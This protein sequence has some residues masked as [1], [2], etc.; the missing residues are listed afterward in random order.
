MSWIVSLALAATTGLALASAAPA[1]LATLA[2]RGLAL[3]A[4]APAL[5]VPNRAYRDPVHKFSFKMYADW[6]Q[7]PVEITEK[8]EVAK[9]YEK[10]ERGDWFSPEINVFRIDKKT[11]AGGPVTGLDPKKIDD[12]AVRK[13]LEAANAPKTVFD[14]AFGNLIM[15]QGAKPC[16]PAS[17]KPI[18]SY[19]K[20]DGKLW[21][22]EIHRG[23]NPKDKTEYLLVMLV[24]FEKEGIE[25]GIRFSGPARR[26]KEFEP[27]LKTMAKSFVFF[28]DKAK[29]VVSLDKVLDGVNITP[30]RRGEIQKG[31]V[32]GWG[33]EV[34]PKKN[35]V[36]IYNTKNNKNKL[37]AETIAKRIEGIREQ[38][39]EVQFP[40]A[41]PVKAVSIVRVCGDRNEYHKYGGP[42]GSAGYWNSWAE[43]L[44]FY[45]ASPAKQIDD[46]TL[47]VLYH[48]A[49]HQYIYYSVGSVAP[50]SWF[51]EGHGDY[52]AGAKWKSNKWKVGPFD[53]RV[54]TVKNAIRQGPRDSAVQKDE[55]TGKE[56]RIYASDKG[57]TPLKDLVAFS[58]GDYYSYPGVSYA[59][60]WSLIYFLREEVPNNKKYAEKWGKILDTY[61]TALKREV[62]KEGKLRRRG[63]GD[64]EPPAPDDPK[65]PGD[66]TEP[67]EPTD[68]TDPAD[69]TPPGEGDE[70]PA[71]PGFQPM[72]EGDVSESA[73]EIAL[74]E[75]FAGVDFAELETAWKEFTLKVSG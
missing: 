55:K 10:G 15:P 38:I 36:I 35:Y 62:N 65:K 47:A 8:Y 74:R 33:V 41:E 4:P 26:R 1:T 19:D 53:W 37:L 12:E 49:F 25:Y 22:H 30:K 39:Y 7:V 9:F 63:F 45:D 17:F 70:P 50:H 11:G 72:Q 16:D 42:G 31:L 73:L 5:D 2:P 51:N 61:F 67:D 43:E 64:D 69:P 56:R 44:V 28:D 71:D 57:Y 24:A 46:D 29:E 48:E 32:K 20:V 13:L 54:G 59:Q 14:L 52:Y 60:G 66:P 58:Q 21:I 23:D 6:E 3:N 18:T 40:P 27:A 75:A 34:S 68:P